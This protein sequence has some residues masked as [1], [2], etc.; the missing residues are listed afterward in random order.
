M[1][2]I[3][4]K[5]RF[6]LWHNK[7]RTLLAVL[8][9]AA[10][11]FAVGAVFGMTDQ[12]LAGMDRAHQ[13]VSPSHITMY[14]SDAIDGD[15]AYD[16]RSIPGVQD[17][18]PHNVIGLSYK[19]RP[20]DDWKQAQIVMR[21]DYRR[22]RNDV[23]QLKGGHWPVKA[24]IG[25][26]R[27]TSAYLHIG[28]GDRVIFKR[29][30]KEVSLP[31][32]GVIRHPFVPPPD[33]GGPAYFFVDGEG[34]ER[35][36]IPDNTYR[37]LLVRV[38]PYSADYAKQV[39]ADIKDS[40][41]RQGIGVTET[42]YQDP[43]KHWGRMYME[44]M[45]VVMQLLAVVSLLMSVVLIYNT[46]SALVAQQTD[47]I[48]ILKAIGGRSGSIASIYLVT[49]LVYG[50]L[51][52]AVSLP[53]SMWLAYAIS[54]WFLNLF[55]IDYDAFQYSSRAVLLQVVS[56]TAIPVLAALLPVM[57]GAMMTVREAI[58]SYG[59]MGSFGKSRIDR[60]VERIS[61]RLLPSHYAATLTNLFRRKGRLLL[62]QV[63][64]VAAG[65]MFLVVMT[66]SS[67]ITHTMDGVFQRRHFDILMTFTD[68]QRTS[69]LEDVA[70]SVDGVEHVEGWYSQPIAIQQGGKRVKEA[71]LGGQII[72]VPPDG[73]VYRE[74]VVAGRWLEPGDDRVVVVNR[75]TAD[76]N[77]IRLDDT[78]TLDLGD[79]GKSDWRVIGL[80]QVVFSGGFSADSV[81][82]PQQAVYSVAK[83]YNQ[84]AQLYVRT[85]THD[86]KTI[87]Q[88]NSSLKT[89]FEARN[90]KLS[91]S[92]TEVEYKR[93][94]DGEFGM[95][96]S[97][98]LSLAV[99]VA[100]VGGLALMGA[101]SLGVVE[102]TKEI[103]VLRAVGA[104]SWTIMGMFVMEGVLQG[105]LSWLLSV[106]LSVAI[107]P[108]VS[109]VLGRAMFSMPLDYRYD[110]G[111]VPVWLATV[112][113]ISAVSSIVP[114]RNASRISVRD[115]LAYA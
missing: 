21:E 47:Q 83:K 72:G 29:G 24:D 1:G 90:M 54:K 18:E 95:M 40:L 36:D 98:L 66:L 85:Q 11:V 63:V 16:L 113:V 89:L 108:L 26:E 22:Q 57:S 79:A 76:K 23:L 110:L 8:S 5:V 39:A 6:D 94:G 69:R 53:I 12:M 41:A 81:Y 62:T 30:S 68:Y 101:L 44:G 48:G 31:I 105:L 59:L 14:L 45:T 99:I 60:F 17:V 97:M 77:G 65:A 51:A 61:D 49:V 9:I 27:L 92:M 55:N 42:F 43:N 35:F 87:D 96:T 58:A 115:S 56:A 109:D 88:V 80:Y 13:S 71:G 82:A 78:V 25:I 70:F 10:G 64:L 84:A 75:D 20:D 86:A 100:V 34:L 111:A 19:L 114:A 2:V 7:V 33:F 102:R 106:V 28:I 46:L 91:Y 3:W 103:G 50:L 93:I 73:T 104:R 67:S 107:G 37:V 15:S 52:L 74:L 112:V 32:G 38:T 4:H